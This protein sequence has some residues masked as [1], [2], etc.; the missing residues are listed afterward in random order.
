MRNIEFVNGEYYHIYNH[1]IDNR[2][3]F[4]GDEDFKRFLKSIKEFNRVDLIGSLND[5]RYKDFCH[6]DKTLSVES[7]DTLDTKCLVEIICY[8][9][10]SNHYHIL[11]KQ[12]M[13]KGI[14]RFMHKLGVGYTNYFNNKYKRRGCLFEGTYK[15]K[16]IDTNEYLL[17]VSGHINGNSEIH[18]IVNADR[19]KW[20]SY[21]DYFDNK[22]ETCNM[23]TIIN[24]FTSRE[25]YKEFVNMVI[26]ESKSKKYNIY[27][28][29]D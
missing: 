1:G 24:Q 25:E 4:M 28:L 27:T 5:K 3:V 9:L 15:A 22:S 18:N 6:G 11:L 19:Y 10:N 13:D 12:L 2:N 17:W 23:D 21:K 14:E 8:C 7:K 20:S 29:E 16:H 26:N